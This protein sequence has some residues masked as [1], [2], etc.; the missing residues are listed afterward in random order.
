MTSYLPGVTSGS[1]HLRG[2]FLQPQQVLKEREARC[3]TSC[4]ACSASQAVRGQQS[5]PSPSHEYSRP[6]FAESHRIPQSFLSASAAPPEKMENGREVS[7]DE[8]PSARYVSVWS[9]TRLACTSCEYNAS[10]ML[11][12]STLLIFLNKLFLSLSFAPKVL[13]CKF[14]GTQ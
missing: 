13:S 9:L 2:P 11:C 6:K 10:F 3:L 5:Y 12:D 8:R 7:E 1:V 14:K 4:S